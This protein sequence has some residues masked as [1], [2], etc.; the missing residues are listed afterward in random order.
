MRLPQMLAR[1]RA[2]EVAKRVD[3]AAVE[4]VLPR[5]TEAAYRARYESDDAAVRAAALAGR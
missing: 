3:M 1:A 4:A 5:V 2:E